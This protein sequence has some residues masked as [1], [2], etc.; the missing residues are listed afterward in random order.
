MEAL[1][2]AVTIAVFDAETIFGVT[3]V[4]S[5]TESAALALEPAVSTI[6]VATFV[7]RVLTA[8]VHRLMVA[9]RVRLSRF[10]PHTFRCFVTLSEP[11]F[12]QAPRFAR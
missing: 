3:M 4:F 1:V 10:I 12:I 7:T 6:F 5:D 8:S 9:R 2:V 11:L